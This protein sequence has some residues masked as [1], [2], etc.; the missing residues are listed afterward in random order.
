MHGTLPSGFREL[1]GQGD[2]KIR[3]ARGMGD[4]KET[5]S[6]RHNRADTHRNSE[7]MVVC[8]EFAQLQ[9]KKRPSAERGTWTWAPTTNQEAICN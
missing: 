9:A 5:V 6:S 7:S 8:T 2:G 3:R 4:T 1:G